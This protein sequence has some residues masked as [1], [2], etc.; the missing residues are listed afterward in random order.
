LLGRWTMPSRYPVVMEVKEISADLPPPC[1][2]HKIGDK[3]S[4][5]NAKCDGTLCLGV[6]TRQYMRLGALANG[7]PSANVITYKCPDQGKV[8]YE[9]RRDPDHWYMDAVSQLTDAK[10]KA[11]GPLA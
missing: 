4:V 1:P 3:S 10:V 9:I 8:V 11:P 7:I 5:H 6:L 2:V